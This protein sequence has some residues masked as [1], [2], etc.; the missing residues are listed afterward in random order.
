MIACYLPTVA[1]V[2]IVPPEDRIDVQG[3]A[4]VFICNATA[5]PRPN[6]TWWRDDMNG[7]PIQVTQ[8]TDKIVIESEP[9][10]E[11]RERTSRLMIL[12]VQP[13]DAGVYRCQA[14]NEAGTVEVT[15]T[16]TVYGKSNISPFIY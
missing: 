5:R 8:E 15:A 4:A 12:D 10:G 2:I 13:S 11:E 7:D 16:L 14:D 9:I 1:P 3:T 6:I